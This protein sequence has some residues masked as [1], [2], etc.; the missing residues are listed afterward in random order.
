MNNLT[1][2]PFIDIKKELSTA[3]KESCSEEIEEKIES[4][5]EGKTSLAKDD[6]FTIL[7]DFYSKVIAKQNDIVRLVY[8]NMYLVNSRLIDYL[9]LGKV[10]LI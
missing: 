4:D 5:G 8:R 9:N 10:L 7:S 6:R 1:E 2:F 3:H